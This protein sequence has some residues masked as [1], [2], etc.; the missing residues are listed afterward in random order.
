MLSRLFSR[1][2]VGWREWISLPDLGVDFIKAKIDTGAKTSVLH[3][4]NIRIVRKGDKRYV[5]FVIY[6]GQRSRH[7]ATPARAL[8]VEKRLIRSSSGHSSKRPVI[9]THIRVGTQSWPIEV[10][11]VDRDV[12]GFR[13]LLGRQ[14]ILKRFVVDPAHSFLIGKRPPR[15][16]EAGLKEDDADTDIFY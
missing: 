10:T 4:D 15:S 5:R 11:L 14:A 7:V 12:M 8:L 9:R 1:K 6:P 2:T 13:M 16:M 3:A